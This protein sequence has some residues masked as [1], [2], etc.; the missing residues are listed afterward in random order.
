MDHANMVHL[1]ICG[2]SDLP[3]ASHCKLVIDFFNANQSRTTHEAA[4]SYNQTLGTAN[5]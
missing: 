4:V 2:D 5:P 1:A 3:R